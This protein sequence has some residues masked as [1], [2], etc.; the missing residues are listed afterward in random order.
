MARRYDPALRTPSS[1]FAGR[2][3]WSRATVLGLALLVGAVE[4]V[5]ANPHQQGRSWSVAAFASGGYQW[6]TGRLAQNVTG[7]DDPNLGLLETVSELAPSPAWAGGI[8]LGLPPQGVLFR[9]GWM[10]TT[11]AEVTGRL[12]VC[13]LLRG[14]LCAPVAAPVTVREAFLDVRL[15]R[16]R[17]E[18]PI[19]PVVS[20]GIGLRRYS[21]IVPTCPLSIGDAR[22]VCLAITDLYTDT[23]DHFVLRFGL[24]ARVRWGPAFV[25]LGGGGSTGRYSGGSG[26]AHGSW[27][28]DFRVES[29]I[30]AILF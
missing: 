3:R 20:V 27:Y 4:S 9:L 10:S 19:R 13:T 16:G 17:S 28:Q 29:S 5:A 23:S 14:E 15:L 1:A 25:E 30:G 26:R 21:Y 6:P 12:G 24:G 11:G 2:G 22:L 7:N 8:E 18:A